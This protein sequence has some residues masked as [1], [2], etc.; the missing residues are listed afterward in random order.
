MFHLFQYLYHWF[1][2]NSLHWINLSYLSY[3]QCPNHV[4]LKDCMSMFYI[5]SLHLCFWKLWMSFENWIFQFNQLC[6]WWLHL[7]MPWFISWGQCNFL[8]HWW[9]INISKCSTC[10]MI[11]MTLFQ[12]PYSHVHVHVYYISQ[13]IC[14]I[15]SPDLFTLDS[16]NFTILSINTMTVV[17]MA[18]ISRFIQYFQSPCTLQFWAFAEYWKFWSCKDVIKSHLI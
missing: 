15:S 8:T 9:S 13:W 2:F 17:V 3:M 14:V 1:F 18:W 16:C 5:I 11:H 7:I 10:W 6:Y 12:S 4:D